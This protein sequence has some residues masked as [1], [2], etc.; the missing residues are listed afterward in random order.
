MTE[1]S[2]LKLTTESR[3]LERGGIGW[4]G[5]FYCGWKRKLKGLDLINHFL[6]ALE[7]PVLDRF[8]LLAKRL[9]RYKNKMAVPLTEIKIKNHARFEMERR[10]IDEA[11]VRTIAAK[12]EQI[13]KTSG[14][15]WIYQ[16]RIQPSDTNKVYLIRVIVDLGPLPPEVITVYRSSKIDKYWRK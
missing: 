13:L 12:P 16:S 4:H 6:Y 1:N 15:R 9:E 7:K 5:L 10:Q 11:T 3:G 14:N 8:D 2:K